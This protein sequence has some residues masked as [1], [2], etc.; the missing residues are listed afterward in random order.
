MSDISATAD[1][2]RR[3]G[4]RRLAEA[5]SFR[6]IS[7]I[8][9][10]VGLFVVF[11]LWVPET[12][13]TAATWRTMLD[14]EALTALVAIAL[15][16][17]LAAG[18]PNLA[19][20]TEVGLGGILVAWFLA[21]QGIPTVPAIA[22]TLAAGALIGTINGLLITRAKINSFIAT[23]GVSSV[24]AAMTA[25]V[26][27]SQ[28]IL[29][30]GSTF[31]EIGTGELF[32]ITYP[33]YI[34]AAVAIVAFYVLEHTSVGRTVYA[35]GGNI[36]AAR[37]AG[38]GTQRAIIGC[39]IACGVIAALAG[40]LQTSRVAT[41]DPTAGPSYLLP[42]FAAVFLGSTQFH[43]GRYNVAG[44]VVG[45]YVLATGVK[46]LQLAGAPVWLP[47]LF[48]GLALLIAVGMTKYTR[49]AAR[50]S[51]ISRAMGRTRRRAA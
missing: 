11:S 32:G 36:D 13:L 34:L 8:Y 44:T 22:L 7:A 47:E 46:G 3:E 16:I 24:L 15:V 50:S 2:D 37:L 42:A 45:V 26:S 33:V 1:P 5:L 9:V 30:L 23:L 17:P 35:T 49:R 48:N 51:A 19:I 40:F 14:N 41:G 28:Q 39:F 38:V 6:R 29:N 25:W 12:F 18:C 20:G 31:Q 27:Q 10:F 4:L 21:K 43:G